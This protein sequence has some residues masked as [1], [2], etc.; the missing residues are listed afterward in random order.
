MV[1]VALNYAKAPGNPFPGPT[2]DVE[3]LLCSALADSDLPIDTGR[4][5]LA[6]WSAGGNLALAAAQ[7]E[8]VRSRIHALVPLYPVID[9]VPSGA[10]KE[11]LRRYKPELGGFRGRDKDYLMN[12]A[13][14]FDWAYLPTGRPLADRYLSPFY[15]APEDLPKNVFIIACELDILSHEDWRLAC[16]LAGRKVP[17]LDE[18]TGREEPAGRGELIMDDERFHFEENGDGKNYRWLLVP[19]AV[20]GFDQPLERIAGDDPELM[21][22]K[23]I[24]TEKTIALI[25]EWLLAGPLRA[26]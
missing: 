21:L 18:P 11:K 5:A 4:V 19:D 9:F 3:A 6:G 8:T 10:V 2:K 24:K 25:G 20:H 17:G 12:M 22:D 1:V 14:V 26:S 23:G 13:P 15:S 16:R 7:L